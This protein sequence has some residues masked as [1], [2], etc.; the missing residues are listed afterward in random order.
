[1]KFRLSYALAALALF[2]VEIAIALFVHDRLI[3]PH[4]GDSLAVILLY[5]ALR[6][7]TPLRV[8]PAA[9][10]ALA[11]AVAIEFGQLFGLIGALGLSGNIA[12]RFLL[13]AGFDPLDF[14]AYAAGALFVIAVERM[15]RR[16]G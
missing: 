6:A 9:G 13:G 10:I 5:L 11:V 15:R 14:I 4:I 3:R 16:T 7:V 1:M 8:M 2:A 12:A